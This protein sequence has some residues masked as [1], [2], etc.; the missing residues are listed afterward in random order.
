M[1]FGALHAIVHLVQ[2]GV[3]YNSVRI[4]WAR[5]EDFVRVHPIEFV[6]TAAGKGICIIIATRNLT[7]E[8]HDKAILVKAVISI[9]SEIDLVVTVLAIIK[10]TI[11]IAPVTLANKPMMGAEF[12]EEISSQISSADTNLVDK[13]AFGI[14]CSADRTETSH[15]FDPRVKQSLPFDDLSKQIACLPLRNVLVVFNSPV[16]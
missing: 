10:E 1:S 6:T 15:S 2:Q 4:L 16:E 11:D 9:G 14:T 3:N 7:Q 5:Q 13:N 8:F 12:N